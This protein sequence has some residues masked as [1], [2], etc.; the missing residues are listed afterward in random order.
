ML[1]LLSKVSNVSWRGNGHVCIS[2]GRVELM[3]VIDIL[4]EI[5]LSFEIKRMDIVF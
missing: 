5:S 2:G 1:L 4:L 3:C